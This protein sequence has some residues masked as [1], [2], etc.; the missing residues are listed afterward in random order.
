MREHGGV[1]GS[2]KVLAPNHKVIAVIPA[3]RADVYDME[4]PDFHNFVANGVVVH[5]SNKAIG[6]FLNTHFD[7]SYLKPKA[8]L[9]R[10][11]VEPMVS[12]L[13]GLRRRFGWA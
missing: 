10:E 7:L 12:P 11:K 9:R 4:V 6:Y 1:V 3:G 13:A 2:A 5:N 8:T